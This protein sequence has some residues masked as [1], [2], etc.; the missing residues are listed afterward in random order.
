MSAKP[1]SIAAAAFSKALSMP[2]PPEIAAVLKFC[3]AFLLSLSTDNNLSLLP[4]I[5]K[6]KPP[7]C[8]FIIG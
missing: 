6:D 8:M 3:I 4:E 2:L 1:F 7:P 5:S